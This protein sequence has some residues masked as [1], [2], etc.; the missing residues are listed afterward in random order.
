MKTVVVAPFS[1]SRTRDWPA[2][3]YNRLIGLLIQD[4]NIR[5]LVIGSS[6]QWVG[7]NE[8]V[9]DYPADRVVNSC[10]W[11]AWSEVLEQIAAADCVI[12][13]NSG[14]AHIAGSMGRTTLCVFGGS[15]SPYE[16]MAR[17]PAVTV[18]TRKVECSPCGLDVDAACPY[19]VRCLVEIP[20][21]RVYRECR[22][23][24]GVS[25]DA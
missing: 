24:L 14:V 2:H 15:H 23:L 4:S 19:G 17:G 9:R 8:V 18:I 6:S 3:H 21:E 7:A 20:P 25:Q 12:A 13:N 5:V 11:M 1:N 16:W 10:G 22:E